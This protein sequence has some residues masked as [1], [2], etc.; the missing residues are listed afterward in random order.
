MFGTRRV[1]FLAVSLLGLGECLR[2]PGLSLPASTRGRNSVRMIAEP[3]ATSSEALLMENEELRQKVLMLEDTIERTEG[4]CEPLMGGGWAESLQSR[5]TWLIGL[6]IAQSCS[7]FILADNE[8]LLATHP[9]V[10]FF[11]TMLVGAGGNAGNQASVRLIRGLATGE[12]NGSREQ[13]M[14][15]LANEARIALALGFVLVAAGFLR[16]VMFEAATVDAF[17][18]SASLFLIVTSSVVLGTA[19][20]LALNKARI[21]AAHA[22]TSIQVIMDVLGVLITCT[23]APLVFENAERIFA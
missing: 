2:A 8:D 19:L 7:S 1:L 22:S 12:V 4:L 13:T 15:I 3:L 10:I 11:L 5:A 6:L 16:V 18:I 9:T 20:P 17:A 21:D 14:E 23:V